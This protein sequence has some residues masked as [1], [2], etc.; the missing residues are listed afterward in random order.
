MTSDYD[1]HNPYAV[2]V[3][4]SSPADH[5]LA[6][7][8]AL[9]RLRTPARWLVWM[10]I[11]SILYNLVPIAMLIINGQ[12]QNSPDEMSWPVFVIWA[13][14]F[15]IIVLLQPLVVLVAGSKVA[16][17]NYR[18]WIWVAIVGGLIPFAVCLQIPFAFW[19]LHL[20]LRKDIR[21]ALAQSA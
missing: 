2:P 7:D 4:S 5:P 13:T 1:R 3:A 20:M 8:K 9:A 17:G 10:G 11:A 21:A 16:A 14:S 19:L 15:S 12:P 18:G 6:R